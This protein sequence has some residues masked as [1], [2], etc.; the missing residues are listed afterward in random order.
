MSPDGQ[1]RPAWKPLVQYLDSL[2]RPAFEQMVA[3]GASLVRESGITYNAIEEEGDQTRPWELTFI[4]LTIQ[5]SA[6]AQLEQGLKQRVRILEAILDDFLGARR[7]LRERVVPTALLYDNPR[8]LRQYHDMPKVGGTRLHIVATDVAREADGSWWVTADRTRAPSGLGY[9]VENRIITSRSYTRLIRKNH[10][11]RLAPFFMKLRQMLESLTPR[12]SLNPRVAILTPG[13]K[14]Y[15]YFEDTYLSRYLGYTLVQGRDLAVRG[16]VLNLKTLGG[17]IP[18]DVLLRHISDEQCDPLELDPTSDE[19]ATGL[20]Q[21]IR[22]GNIAVANCL[23]SQLAQTPALMPFIQAASQFLLQ[24]DPI[25][26]MVPTYWC[27]DPEGLKF[28]LAHLDEINI[29]P[30][31]EVRGEKPIRP[32]ELGNADREHLVARIKATPEAFVAQEEIQRSTTPVWHE[33]KLQPWYV[34]LRTFQISDHRGVEVLPGG[35]VRVSPLVDTIDHSYGASQL[36]QDCWVFADE[37]VD[38]TAS[39]LPPSDQPLKLVRGGAELPSRVAENLFWLGRYS[40]RAESISR[41]L[42]TTLMRL[43]G[44]QY[45][46]STTEIPRLIAALAAIGQIEPDYAVEGLAGSLPGLDEM[47]PRSLFTTEQS[48]GLS[49]SVNAMVNQAT[50]VRDRIS[51]DAYRIVQR[52]QQ[53]LR[54]SPDQ[55]GPIDARSA[56]NRL[57]RLITDLLAFAGLGQESL[58]RTLGWRFLQLGR[59]IER[60]CQTAELLRSTLVMG[61]QKRKGQ[62]V[63]STDDRPILEAVL[64][65]CDSI[66]TYRSRY[67]LRIEPAAAIDL[68]VTDTINPR[69]IMFQLER[70]M[71][72]MDELPTEAGEVALPVERR[73][74]LDLLHKVRMAQ[75]ELLVQQNPSGKRESL[76][77]LLAMLTD[78]LPNLSEQITARYLIHTTPSQ[79]LTGVT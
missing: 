49:P 15:R 6:W 48:N 18:I 59:R 43:S 13:Q 64:E 42:R 60:A 67:L 22:A 32:M 16:G 8:Y 5:A 21:T 27:G 44:E 70:I 29:R 24:E 26:P 46:I 54:H 23:G 51:L 30:A 52:V 71:E 53:E 7:L 11:R 37:P 78:V 34:A 50:A 73:T 10:I 1:I 4:P 57:S 28:V 14:S 72:V 75:P 45:P 19:G 39:L 40:E 69:S 20:V 74:V 33:G 31:F 17:L 77:A 47:L 76:D 68:L 66:M 25:L 35:L 61:N 9:L 65:A 2:G 38:P 62:T 41:L 3:E 79:S 58:T 12:P 55:D 36:G 56:I 63:I